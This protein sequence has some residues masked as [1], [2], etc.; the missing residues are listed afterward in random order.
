MLKDNSDITICLTSAEDVTNG[1]GENLET[2]VIPISFDIDWNKEIGKVDDKITLAMSKD[3]AG[4]YK[5]GKDIEEYSGI[6]E[7]DVVRE[8]KA[9][10]EKPDD[11]I[12]YGLSNTMNGGSDVYFWTNGFRLAGAAAK[13]GI[14][15]AIMEHISHESLH[16]TRKLLTR[17]IARNKKVNISNGDW[18]TFDY[19]AGKYSWPSVGDPNDKTPKI[20]MIDEEAFATSVGIVVQAVTP[21]FLDMASVYIPQLAAMKKI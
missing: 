20:I 1:I 10:K 3:S 15:P 18:I 13:V 9:G 11:A 2:K 19:G 16:L 5:I 8:I 14:W 17:A 12:I 21:H 6:P 7:A 4:V